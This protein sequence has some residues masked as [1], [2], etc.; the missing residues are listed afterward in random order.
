MREIQLLKSPRIQLLEAKWPLY[1]FPPVFSGTLFLVEIQEHE[2]WMWISDV[3]HIVCL[4]SSYCDF[5]LPSN[6]LS[7][8]MYILY[9]L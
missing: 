8:Q 1:D 4:D 2:I 3:T 7:R 9:G 6:R 5:L